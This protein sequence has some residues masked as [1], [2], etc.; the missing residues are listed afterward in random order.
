MSDLKVETGQFSKA[1]KAYRDA[2]AAFDAAE[3]TGQ[4]FIARHPGWTLAIGVLLLLGDLY[5]AFKAYR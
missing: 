1:E 3:G 2:K 5:F 4:N